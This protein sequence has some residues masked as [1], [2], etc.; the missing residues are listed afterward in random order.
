MTRK[1]D[2]DECEQG[3]FK[4]SKG[5]SLLSTPMNDV[6]DRRGANGLRVG[7]CAAC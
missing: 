6:A 2:R 5:V 4:W 3:G 7:R 1:S